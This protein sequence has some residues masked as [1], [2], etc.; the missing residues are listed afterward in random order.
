MAFLYSW[1]PFY[2][3]HY[4]H[5]DPCFVPL[6]LIL[7]QF[8]QEFG[9]RGSQQYTGFGFFSHN[10]NW[11]WNRSVKVYRDF[12][13]KHSFRFIFIVYFLFFG[14]CVIPYKITEKNMTI[15]F[16]VFWP[17]KS[18]VYDILVIKKTFFKQCF[19]YFWPLLELL[20]IFIIFKGFKNEIFNLMFYYSFLSQ[21]RYTF[22]HRSK[23]L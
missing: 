5:L 4:L 14:I 9:G 18:K 6:G 20:K 22:C 19:C 13:A 1:S 23:S 7:L 8:S 17:K 3:V 2:I 11:S 21:K 16:L 12:H 10:C 15:F